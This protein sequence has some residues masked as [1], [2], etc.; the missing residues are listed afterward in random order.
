MIA[1]LTA[2]SITIGSP[3]PRRLARFYADL[4]GWP[5]TGEEGPGPGEPEDAG[6][7]QLKPLPGEPGMTI[8]IEWERHFQRPVW[9][10][11]SG[12]QLASQ[13]LDIR[14]TGELGQA[15]RWAVERGAVPAGVQPQDGVRVLID[16]DG[17]PF[18]LF[19]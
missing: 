15:E 18:C 16:P 2:T 11:E 5:L 10:A 3:R 8:N 6:W 12:R 19:S 9:P 1:T 13:H 17:H 7:A 4:L 14:V